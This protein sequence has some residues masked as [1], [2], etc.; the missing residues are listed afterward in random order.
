MTTSQRAVGRPRSF[1][2]DEM[3]DAA[4]ELFWRHGAASTT[5]RVL[6]AELGVTQSSLYN[7]FGSKEE[8]INRVL[9]RYVEQIDTA[10]VGPLD[11]PDAGIDELEQFVHDMVA[12]ISN[13]DRQGCMLLNL[14]AERGAADQ[15][16]VQRASSYRDRIRAACASALARTDAAL[17]PVRAEVV[18]SCV[19]GINIAARGGAGAA[20]LAAMADGLCAQVRAWSDDD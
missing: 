12:W 6:E 4:M 3:L 11:Q 18:L 14:L 17:A 10:V 20:E 8:L 19:L 7:A 5:T 13:D 9:D 1:D 2:E 15:V 16:L